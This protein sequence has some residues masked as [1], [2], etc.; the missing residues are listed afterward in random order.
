MSN[1]K[2]V[3][4]APAARR[5]EVAKRDFGAQLHVLRGMR[6]DM[7]GH[8]ALD[9]RPDLVEDGNGVSLFLWTRT[10]GEAFEVTK[11]LL[12][13]SMGAGL[14]LD[15]RPA[16]SPTPLQPEGW[17]VHLMTTAEVVS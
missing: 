14:S 4:A 7:A 16:L 15:C 3:V 11:A 12:P 5:V 10:S 6:A 2:T 1:A 9:G 13:A 17:M 8:P